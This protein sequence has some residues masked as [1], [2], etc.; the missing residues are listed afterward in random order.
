[1]VRATSISRHNWQS[2]ENCKGRK[3]TSSGSQPTSFLMA[4]WKRDWEFQRDPI[5]QEEEE[6][7]ENWAHKNEIE[8]Q[9][10]LEQGGENFITDLKNV[11]DEEEYE[12][13]QKETKA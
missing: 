13:F 11:V 8:Q 5:I 12:I 6:P 7:H 9:Q 3:K 1:M 10:E 2:G 4:P